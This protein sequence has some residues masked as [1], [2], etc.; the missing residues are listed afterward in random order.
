MDNTENKE[1]I[2]LVLQPHLYAQ[3]VNATTEVA[4]E[5]GVFNT[6]SVRAKMESAINKFIKLGHKV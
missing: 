1:D 4:K 3:L 6:Q 2:R 5:H